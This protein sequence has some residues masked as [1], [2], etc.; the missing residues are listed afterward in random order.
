MPSLLTPDALAGIHEKLKRANENIV[1]LNSEID[2]FIKV[3]PNSGIA[4]AKP[5]L[6]EDW[7][8]SHA[9]QPI[10]PRFAV[11]AGEVI[12][13]LRSC[14]DHIAW[15]LSTDTY[16]KKA[17]TKIAFPILIDRP[18]KKAKARY[19]RNVAGI[20]S[21]AALKHIGDL[22][23]YKRPNSADQPLAIIHELDRID[24]HHELVIVVAAFEARL[25]IPLESFTERM[26]NGMAMKE[27]AFVWESQQKIDGELSRKVAFSKFGERENQSV[28]PSL[29]QLTDAIRDVVRMFAAL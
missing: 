27:E 29:K 14:L 15:D 26:I 1:N 8:K 16:R 18:D 22:Q 2:A 20:A 7:I 13:H 4:E 28:I 3:S 5:Q 6:P 25:H 12:H 10:P 21:P 24:K 9:Q 19:D 23:P 11:V 17:E